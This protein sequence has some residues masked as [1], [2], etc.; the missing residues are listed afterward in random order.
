MPGRGNRYSYVVSRPS[1]LI[2]DLVVTNACLDKIRTTID[3]S[4]HCLLNR[5]ILKVFLQDT[6]LFHKI[7]SFI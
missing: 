7:E 3:N 4:I 6:I 2:Q 5:I 1:N